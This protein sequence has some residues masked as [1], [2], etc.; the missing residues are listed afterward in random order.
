MSTLQETDFDIDLDEFEMGDLYFIRM[1]ASNLGNMDVIAYLL[2]R[3]LNISNKNRLQNFF[4]FLKVCVAENYLD[5]SSGAIKTV[6][7][8]LL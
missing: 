2:D 7:N 3:F 8:K 1:A 5:F 6:F 4:R